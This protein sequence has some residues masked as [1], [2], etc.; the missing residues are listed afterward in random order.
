MR[1]DF[2]TTG[3]DCTLCERVRPVLAAEAARLGFRLREIDVHEHPAP[4]SDY[5]FRTPVIHVDG[6]RIDEGRID[7][8]ALRRRIIALWKNALSADSAGGGEG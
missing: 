2:Y 8:G 5:V 3:P 7:P 4:E 6:V 1:V